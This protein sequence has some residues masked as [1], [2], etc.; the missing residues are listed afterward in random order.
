MRSLPKDM[1]KNQE[2]IFVTR[3]LL[4]DLDDLMVRLKD[5]WDSKWLSNGGHQHNTLEQ[6]IGERLAVPNVSLFSNGTIALLVAIQSL[7]LQ[8][9]VITTPFTFPA[10]THVLWWN[11]VTP[12][13]AD[14]DPD[15]MTLDPESVERVITQRTSGILGVHVYGIPCDVAGLG[16]VADRHGLRVIYDAAHAFE[17]EI[18]GVGIGNFGDIS[19]FSF[20]PTK[21]FHSGE[22][23]CLTYRDPNLKPRIDLL[24]NFGIRNEFEV[25]MPGINGKMNELQAALG[26]LVLEIVDEERARRSQIRQQ[27]EREL[28]DLP[29]LI[30]PKVDAGVKDSGQYF[31]IRIKPSEF[32]HSRDQVYEAL[33]EQNIFARKYFFPLTSDYTCYRSLNSARPELLPN[34]Q[35]VA[36]EV[37]CLPYYGELTESDVNEICEVIR[38]QARPS[39]F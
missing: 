4:P 36:G 24:K 32:G 37:L 5:V 39:A 28:G 9:E 10:T 27:Y 6:R 14:I 31:V 22:G 18:G 12:V 8:G 15:T 13:F 21:L 2:P 20:H 23:G 17:T 29:G 34:A 16:D 25:I 3:P 35:M 30:I 11:G 1:R 19:M 26:H 7:R 38:S 33:R